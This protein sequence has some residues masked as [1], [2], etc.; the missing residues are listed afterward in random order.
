[1]IKF[2]TVKFKHYRQAQGINERIDSGE[3]TDE[4]VLLFAL[5]LVDEWDFVDA[6]NGNT[7][8]EIGE[9]DELSMEQVSE[10]NEESARL[11]GVTAE[12]PKVS[13]EPSSST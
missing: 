13:E 8:L 12:V 7:P 1:M 3:A 11:M 4:E 9:L 10:V 6:D 5:S 2:K